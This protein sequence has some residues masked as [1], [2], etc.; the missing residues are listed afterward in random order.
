MAFEII[1]YT[2]SAEPERVDKTGYLSTPTSFTGTLREGT[3][4]L[5]PSFLINASGVPS[6]NYAYVAEFGRYYYVTDIASVSNN[7]WRVSMDVDALMTYRETIKQ[8]RGIILRNENEFDLLMED[9]RLPAQARPLRRFVDSVAGSNPF[10]DAMSSSVASYVIITANGGIQSA[11]PS[12]NGPLPSPFNGVNGYYITYQNTANDLINKVWSETPVGGYT[13]YLYD[14]LGDA[15]ISIRAYPFDAQAVN[16]TFT[17]QTTT[18]KIGNITVTPTTGLAPVY[19]AME[20]YNARLHVATITFPMIYTDFR[21]YEPYTKLSLYLPFVGYVPLNL[22]SG[23]AGAVN[24][25]Y[26]IDIS[27]GRCTVELVQGTQWGDRVIS[28]YEGQCGIDIPISNSGADA[29]DTANMLAVRQ[30]SEEALINAV[31]GIG[32]G[33]ISND[34]RAVFGST[35]APVVSIANSALSAA[36]NQTRNVT[37]GGV[38]SSLNAIYLPLKP[39]GVM[40]YV[41]EVAVYDYNKLYGRPLNSSRL[42]SE[43]SGYTEVGQIHM[44]NF[45]EALPMEMSKIENYL[46]NGVIL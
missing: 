32:G 18:M 7:L 29:R 26:N 31:A 4:L 40:E 35:L 43:V 23:R 25:Y 27:S 10:N 39:F 41:S 24:I 38:A 28:T 15:I 44:E 5:Q 16:T 37:T 8:Q 13:Q 45:S 20:G 42:L 36:R 19:Y 12:G 9:D 11:S 1:F 17:E 30:A 33:L 34:M 3:N 46:H 14:N 2:N 22:S 6:Y 21:D